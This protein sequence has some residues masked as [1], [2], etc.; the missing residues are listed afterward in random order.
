MVPSSASASVS[1]TEAVARPDQRP[2]TVL[3]VGEMGA[4]ARREHAVRMTAPERLGVL[5]RNVLVTDLRER[6]DAQ[7]LC[8]QLQPT[9][10]EA[11]VV[12]VQLVDGAARVA[13]RERQP[14]VVQRAQLFTQH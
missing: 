14:R 13:V 7:N 12:A 10:R 5:A 8:F 9:T 3:S 4:N 6:I 11:A 1:P 2:R